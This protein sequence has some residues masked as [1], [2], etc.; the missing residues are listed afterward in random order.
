MQIAEPPAIKEGFLWK[1]GHNFRSWKKR[2]CV[3]QGSLLLYFET[4]QAAAPLGWI[5]LRGARLTEPKSSR[6]SRPKLR[7]RNYWGDLATSSWTSQRVTSRTYPASLR[8]A[9]RKSV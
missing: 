2:W 7:L 5:T 9:T 3:L 8:M 1:E 6:G 4:E